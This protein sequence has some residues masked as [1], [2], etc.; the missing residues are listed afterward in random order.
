[1]YE[2]RAIYRYITAKHPESGLVP[3]DPK[4]NAVFEQAAVSEVSNFDPS[5]SAIVVE[6]ILKP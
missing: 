2:T 5:A 1:L 4:A 3:T 6:T